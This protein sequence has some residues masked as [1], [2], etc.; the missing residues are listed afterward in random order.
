LSNLV[1]CLTLRKDRRVWEPPVQTRVNDCEIES[2]SI[3]GLE[4]ISETACDGHS[5]GTS[6]RSIIDLVD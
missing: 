3:A 2:G 4:V 1:V 5:V 6:E